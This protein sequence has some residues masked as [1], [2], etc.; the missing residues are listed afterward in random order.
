MGSAA[1]L[2][3]S[4]DL[5]SDGATAG[6]LGVAEGMAGADGRAGGV[7]GAGVVPDVEEAVVS[8]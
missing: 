1:V 5:G 3:D 7:S 6:E 2:G 4:R 8:A